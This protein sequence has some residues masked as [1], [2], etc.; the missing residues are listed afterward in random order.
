MRAYIF[1]YHLRPGGVTGV[2]T[3]SLRAL[4]GELSTV[5]EFIVVTGEEPSASVRKEI[6]GLADILV[7]EEIGYLSLAQLSEPPRPSPMP[8]GM[9]REEKQEYRSRQVAALTSRIEAQLIRNCDPSRSLWWVHNH[10]LGKNPVFTETLL[11]IGEEHPQLPLLLQIHDFPEEARYANLRFLNLI[12]HRNPYPVRSKAVFAV[13]N[14]RDLRHLREAG[15]PESRL[16]LLPNPIPP[17]PDREAPR[18]AAPAGQRRAPGDETIRDRLRSA[19]IRSF[20]LFDPQAPIALYPVRTIRRK[21]VMEAAFLLAALGRPVNL[22]VTLPGVSQQERNYSAMVE[23]AYREGIIRGLWGIGTTVEEHGI[24]FEELL[25]TADLFVSSSVQ[26]GFGFQYIDSL[27]KG[28]PLIARDLPVLEDLRPL[29]QGAHFY[30][31]LQV[32]TSTPS[33]SDVRPMLRMKYQQRIEQVEPTL[34]DA[35]IA[36]MEEQAAALVSAESVDFSY[37]MPQ[38]QYSYLKDLQV[39]SFRADVAALNPQLMRGVE[40]AISSPPPPRPEAALA[41]VEERFGFRAYRQRVEEILDSFAT[42][43]TEEPAAPTAGEEVQKRLIERFA[44][45]DKLRLLFE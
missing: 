31:E 12:V 19:Y 13:I 5:E 16:R 24:S 17:P 28:R 32:P 3:T 39:D 30:R 7:I 36:Q 26:E 9:S 43:Q 1:H 14:S 4:A 33:L 40:Q 6:E 15:V 25:S 38:M 29:L 35:V 41:E 2:I 11:K 44:G 37:L 23:H 8:T 22:V 42:G 10:H 18:P 27:A 45:L 21:N 34:P 20:P